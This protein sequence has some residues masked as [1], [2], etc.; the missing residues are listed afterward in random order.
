[1]L[2]YKAREK[3]RNEFVNFN[4]RH[5]TKV[6]PNTEEINNP[7]K[8]DNVAQLE[9]KQPRTVTPFRPKT[10]N[11]SEKEVYY[12]GKKKLSADNG[13]LLNLDVDVDLCVY[14]I[15]KRN[16][17]PFLLFSLFKNEYRDHYLSWLTIS[18]KDKQIE[19]IINIIKTNIKGDVNNVVY[20]GRYKHGERTQLWFC[21][22]DATDVINSG[23]FNDTQFWAISSE[24]INRK[25]LLTFSVNRNIIKFFLENPDFLYLKNNL[26]DIY[27]S[28]SI[29]YYGNHAN[30]IT[31][32]ANVGV[33]RENIDAKF[34]PYY[35]YGD[36]SKA[37]EYAVQNSITD[38]SRTVPSE[39]AG[40]KL[41]INDKG[42]FS[43]GG[44]LRSV[45]FLGNIILPTFEIEKIDDSWT[46]KGNSIILRSNQDKEDSGVLL[47]LE[48]FEQQ[49]PLEYY[50]IA[51]EKYFRE[52]NSNKVH[53]D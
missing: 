50:Y 28:P 20:E 4:K 8:V 5:D 36:Y 21:C 17:K 2:S 1:M 14:C 24:I 11:I 39:I 25:K 51:S 34:G 37:I 19:D 43:K 38:S 48:N 42:R 40:E 6:Y 41:I 18:A 26:G 12:S 22:D 52:K 33:I 30:R 53:V 10:E 46:F 49:Y 15:A 3:I 45:V 29:A 7:E 35:Y 13:E 31:F 44:L 32:T 47:V 16:I 23:K 9:Y 27:E